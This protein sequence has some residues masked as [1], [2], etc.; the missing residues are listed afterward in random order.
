M[1]T[2]TAE[3]RWEIMDDDHFYSIE[4]GQ[5]TLR[6]QVHLGEA[7][8]VE[9]IDA[10]YHSGVLTVRIPVAEQAK[11]RK[12]AVTISRESATEVLG[13]WLLIGG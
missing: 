9:N 11:S 7:L 2:V 6:R 10:S 8:D 4:R 3:R 12:V 5:G 13:S 1:L